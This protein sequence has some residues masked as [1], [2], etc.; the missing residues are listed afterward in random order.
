[1]VIA[2]RHWFLGVDNYYPNLF[3]HD[4]MLAEVAT[5]KTSA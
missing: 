4:W 2:P 3:P 5:A 1:M